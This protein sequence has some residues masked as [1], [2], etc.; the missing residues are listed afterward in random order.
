MIT[1]I[2][3][4][5]K[6]LNFLEDYEEL[7]VGVL[8]CLLKEIQSLAIEKEVIIKTDCNAKKRDDLW[9]AWS[10]RVIEMI[11]TYIERFAYAKCVSEMLEINLAVWEVRPKGMGK[12]NEEKIQDLS[13]YILEYEDILVDMR[14]CILPLLVHV[15][16][17][18]NRI[19]I[20]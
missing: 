4:D 16:T 19:K 20:I 15:N 10:S 2:E 13:K 8:K 14:I 12:N 5:E 7:N 1:S 9:T 11:K 6:T 3:K 17:I 18:K